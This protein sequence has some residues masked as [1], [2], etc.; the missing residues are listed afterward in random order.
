ME[1]FLQQ[2]GDG[3]QPFG[4]DPLPDAALQRRL[5]VVAKIEAVVLIN[6]FRQELDLDGL[7]VQLLLL[8]KE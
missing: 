2:P 3:A 1:H 5:R 8:R 6:A 4:V 7:E